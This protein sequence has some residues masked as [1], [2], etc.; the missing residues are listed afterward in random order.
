MTYSLI[1]R[2]HEYFPNPLKAWVKKDEGNSMFYVYVLML[3]CGKFYVGHTRDLKDR[4]A[5]HKEGQT[6]STAGE[7]PR[8][9]YFEIFP[10]REGA[11]RREQELKKV[12]KHNEREIY[13]MIWNFHDVISELDMS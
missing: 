9:R 6:I 13:R 2:E 7:N 5:E 3:N 11:M 8:L 1:C 12:A 10:T 4:I